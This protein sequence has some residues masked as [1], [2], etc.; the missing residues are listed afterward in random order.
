MKL[1]K[2]EKT[3]QVKDT[4]DLMVPDGNEY[5][6]NGVAVHNSTM[7]NQ[8]LINMVGRGHNTAMIPLEMTAEEC[9]GRLMAN[10]AKIDVSKFLLR[11]V[12]TNER[13][14][15]W[16]TY[17]KWVL[18]LKN[19]DVRWTIYRPEI[20]VSIEDV[21]F[22][23]KPYGYDVILI[24]YISLLKGVDGDDQ[25]RQLG[26]VARFAKTWAANNNIVVVLLVQVGLDG[27][28]RYAR[29]IG[30]HSNN[31]FPSGTLID[32]SRGM[33][34][35]EKLVEDP[36]KDQK[37]DLDILSEGKV[38]KATH[39]WYNG[40]CDTYELTDSRGHTVRATLDQKFRVL[41]PDFKIRWRKLSDLQEGDWLV[42][43]SFDK[44]L[45]THKKVKLP[46]FQ[47]KWKEANSSASGTSSHV[48]VGLPE[49]V[50]PQLAALVGY[51]IADG[52]C[53]KN[54]LG[55][56]TAD[57]ELTRHFTQCLDFVFPGIKYTTNSYVNSNGTMMHGVY[58]YL[59][60]V[61]SYFTALGGVSGGAKNKYIPAGIFKAGADCL[62]SCLSALFDCDG[63]ASEDCRLYATTSK[64]LVETYVQALRYFGINSNVKVVPLSK[65]NNNHSDQYHITITGNAN[66]TRY[67]SAVPSLLKRKQA[68][69]K[70]V[71]YTKNEMILPYYANKLRERGHLGKNRLYSTACTGSSV[72][73]SLSAKLD[74]VKQPEHLSLLKQNDPELY[75]T[76]NS[77]IR[78][79]FTFTQVRGVNYAGK[80]DVF[81]L[82]VPSNHTF[83]ANSYVVHNCWIWTYSDENKESGII[84]VS[85]F[86]SRNQKAFPFQLAVDFSTMSIRDVK[87][88]EA[89]NMR[90]EKGDA[91]RQEME[92]MEDYLADIG[93][94]DDG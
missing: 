81:D 92:D 71:A 17:K 28:I 5:V 8:L 19:N 26:N 47:Q 65:Q 62:S 73:E 54:G 90:S 86:K 10:L 70:K 3:H 89:E 84:E 14:K 22:M 82:S 15:A 29:S 35:I 66:L 39:F 42:K 13:K 37:I 51:L 60:N 6:A 2:I 9:T 50:T 23:L 52:W 74:L 83:V 58:C 4:Y 25:W 34:P 44:K 91:I 63:S 78:A 7:A 36:Y 55:I 16:D 40:V 11:K 80:E 85:P 77:I 48:T 64:R 69:P 72:C 33:I 57:P 93:D 27:A 45:T 76:V 18:D 49:Y 88:G 20:D 87:N 46:I 38:R 32:T 24:D 12:T 30:E 75:D 41:T 43:E 79:D 56:K 68:K 53:S 94:E 21:M 1:V 59:S 31:C 67:C 61:T